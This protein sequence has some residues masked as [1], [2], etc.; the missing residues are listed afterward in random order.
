MIRWALVAHQLNAVVWW[1]I[2]SFGI[3]MVSAL[4]TTVRTSHTVSQVSATFTRGPH[5]HRTPQGVRLMCWR[6]LHGTQVESGGHDAPFRV[7][8]MHGVHTL[9]PTLT[10]TLI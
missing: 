6:G 8:Y 10:H 2:V 3:T 9:T 4:V 5:L 7:D 1:Q